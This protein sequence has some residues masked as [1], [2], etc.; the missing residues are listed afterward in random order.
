[1]VIAAATVI[2]EGAESVLII[3]LDAHCGGGTHSMIEETERIQQMDVSVNAVDAYWMNHGN[4]LDLVRDA[5]KYLPTIRERL[6]GMTRSFD[7]ILYNAGMDPDERCQVG[8]LPG[9]NAGILRRREQIVFEWAKSRQIPVAFVLAGGYSGS[10]LPQDELV[11][12]HRMTL[13]C[14]LRTV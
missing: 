5:E 14:A 10:E 3:D 8:G 13:E 1:L 12:L 7:L 6:D 2:A 11:R 4:T 9:I